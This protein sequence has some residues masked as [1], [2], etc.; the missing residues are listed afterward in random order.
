M[1]QTPQGATAGALRTAYARFPP[2]APET[3]TDEASLLEACTIPVHAVL[4]DPDNLKVTLPADLARASAMLAGRGLVRHGIGH[5]SHPFG[6]GHGLALGGIVIDDAP[7]L[8][9]HSD[10]DV[11]LHAIADA[12]ARGGWSR[13]SRPTLPGRSGRRPK[14]IA[15]TELLGEVRRRV[16]AV[17]WQVTGVDMTIVAARP[18][19]ASYL[20]AMRDA[21]AELLGLPARGR[22]REG[23]DGQP[24]RLRGGWSVDQRARRSRPSSDDRDRPIARHADRRDAA[25]RAPARRWRTDLLVRTHRLRPGPHR[26]LPVV[27]VRRPARPPPALAW[28]PGDLGH[29]HHRHRRQDHPGRG[30]GRASASRAGRPVPGRRSSRMERPC[31]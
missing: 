30:G 29:E 2:D 28:L 10:G 3:W 31:G 6:P 26:Q 8:Y 23:L 7:R 5:D 18:R 15:S 12:A 22:Q 27:P 24:R 14:G 9:G 4:G 11:A 17:G 19:L 20:D 13:R 21:I 16:E 1:A 25:V